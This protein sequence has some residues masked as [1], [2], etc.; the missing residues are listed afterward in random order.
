MTSPQDYYAAVGA[1]SMPLTGADGGSP[2]A[3]APAGVLRK[4]GLS[5]PLLLTF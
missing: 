4:Q 1:Q 3:A 5:R 2:S